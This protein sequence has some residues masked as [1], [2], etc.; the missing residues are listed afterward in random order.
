M[1]RKIPKRNLTKKR[2]NYESKS[3]DIR[4]VLIYFK[5]K[6][7]TISENIIKYEKDVS[8]CLSNYKRK[9]DINISLYQKHKK[10]YQNFQKINSI[11]R[12][13]Q[14]PQE[15]KLISDI[16]NDYYLKKHMNISKNEMKENIFENSALIEKNVD[17]LKMDYL[18]NYKR[19]KNEINKNKSYSDIYSKFAKEQKSGIGNDLNLKN[20]NSTYLNNNLPGIIL[21]RKINNLNAVKYMK[22][23]DVIAKSKIM[24]NK[25]YNKA[26]NKTEIRNKLEELEKN[27]IIEQKY[28]NKRNIKDILKDI[29]SLQKNLN[30]LEKEESKKHTINLLAKNIQK[31]KSLFYIPTIVKSFPELLYDKLNKNQNNVSKNVATNDSSSPSIIRPT[32]RSS[33]QIINNKINFNEKKDIN[34]KT[35]F[36]IKSKAITKFKEMLKATKSKFV[37]IDSNLFNRT[38]NSK[39]SKTFDKQRSEDN[40]ETTLMYKSILD[41]SN[42]D[43]NSERSST[44]MRTFLKEK[45]NNYLNSVN[46][47]SSKNYYKSLRRIHLQFDK[48][49]ST[50]KFY[51][52]YGLLNNKKVN[53][54]FNEIRNFQKTLR[55]NEK[56]LIKTL[57]IEK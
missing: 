57:L 19:I 42:E 38:M 3:Q 55:M 51:G 26:I 20:D 13:K 37:K 32:E 18:L 47:N 45:N 35:I 4:D 11:I 36:K 30:L 29:Q 44:L 25:K 10:I 28:Q 23:L 21:S 46:E 12:E 14:K 6:K 5:N 2:K 34:N 52:E 27:A 7:R 24:E 56:L 53:Y 16:M 50:E 48:D 33:S 17:R 31:G 41:M 49:L 40:D 1:F 22:K 43:R 54:L 9:S 8:D 15:K 39:P